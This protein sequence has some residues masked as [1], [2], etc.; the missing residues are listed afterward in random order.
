MCGFQRCSSLCEQ[1]EA[2]KQG[3][4]QVEV[5]KG[6]AKCAEREGG[7]GRAAAGPDKCPH[8]QTTTR[9]ATRNEQ[10]HQESAAQR[11]STSCTSSGNRS[12]TQQ[13]CFEF[14]LLSSLKQSS[15]SKNQ[16][17]SPKLSIQVSGYLDFRQSRDD[18]SLFA[19]SISNG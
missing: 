1:T 11:G 13:V 15:K 8:T 12:R 17:N 9:A 7:R 2:P 16:R 10:W 18:L 4:A 14:G 5:M 3:S 19:V 6:T